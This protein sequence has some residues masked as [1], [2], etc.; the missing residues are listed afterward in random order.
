M[1]FFS[2]VFACGLIGLIVLTTLRLFSPDS[3]F[4]VLVRRH[5]ALKHNC[6]ILC[7]LDFW[8]A[9]QSF[10][11]ARTWV[12]CLEARLLRVAL[13][14]DFW[15]A[16]LSFWSVHTWTYDH[17]APLL[18]VVLGLGFWPWRSLF[19]AF[20]RGSK[21]LKHVSF[22]LWSTIR[23][24][25][26]VKYKSSSIFVTFKL[27]AFGVVFYCMNHSLS[28]DTRIE[29]FIDKTDGDELCSKSAITLCQSGFSGDKS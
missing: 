6:F 13:R 26:A 8:T 19:E 17:I 22:I 29:I 21:A 1:V 28:F 27:T 10:W 16:T 5:N 9:T 20:I 3:F 7:C 2:E 4:E 11:S 25:V 18:C 12:Q 24:L 14:L 15:P 23:G